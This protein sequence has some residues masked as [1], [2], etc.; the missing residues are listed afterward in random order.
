MD[1]G[2]DFTDS[3]FDTSLVSQIGDV[4]A[5]FSND[6]S[7][8][9]GG[10]ERAEC[11]LRCSVIFISRGVRIVLGDDVVHGSIGILFLQIGHVF[12]QSTFSR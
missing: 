9:L 3:S 10:D 1:T 6:D 4:F 11:D 2:N 7:G 8:F 5:L 12:F